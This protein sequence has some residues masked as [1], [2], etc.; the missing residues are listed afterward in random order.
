VSAD[1]RLSFGEPLHTER[2]GANRRWAAIDD[3]LRQ[4]TAI[5]GA[6]LKLLPLSPVKINNPSTSG[7][8]SRIGLP[9]SVSVITPAQPTA[10]WRVR[11]VWRAPGELVSRATNVVSINTLIECIWILEGAPTTRHTNQG[12]APA[13]P[14]GSEPQTVD[15]VD[16]DRPRVC[17]RRW[18]AKQR[19]LDSRRPE[20]YINPKCTQTWEGS[21]HRRLPQPSVLQSFRGWSGREWRVHRSP[22]RR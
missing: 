6:V 4:N 21:R 13:R 7:W 14:F 22:Q 19:D 5:A 2:V 16:A 10:H 9:S 17:E 15:A 1:E 18:T 11:H 3:P 20:P 8:R 12:A